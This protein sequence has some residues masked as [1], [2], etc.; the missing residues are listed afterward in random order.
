MR[1]RARAY[2]RAIE[3]L[4][5]RTVMGAAVCKMVTDVSRPLDATSGDE[6]A[7]PGPR[8]VSTCVLP[9]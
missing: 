9:E 2:A 4:A 8:E 3:A 7:F 1:R 6:V 5:A